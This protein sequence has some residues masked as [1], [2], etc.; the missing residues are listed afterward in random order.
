MRKGRN[1][2]W[3]ISAVLMLCLILLPGTE[4]ICSAGG[5]GAEDRG[6][7]LLQYF[8]RELAPEKI[9]MILAD[10][11]DGEGHVR[12]IYLDLKGCVIGGVRID[13]LRMDAVGVR[14]N[15]PGEWR[16]KGIEPLE[17]LN[18]HAVARLTEY[19]LN[20]NLLQKQFGDDDS[21]RNLQVDIHPGGI[22]A[23][24]NY[25]AQFIF[26]LDI[27]IE[28]FSKFKIVD[29]QQVWLDDYS[30]RVNRMDIP[31]F[32]T[33][34]A[35]A[36]IQPLL[37]LGKFVFPLKLHS[38]EYDEEAITI[39]S[40]VIPEPFPGVVYSWGVPGDQAKK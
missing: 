40:R 1:N 34:K 33:D 2:L 29:M 12:E 32:I 28:I 19:D 13:T 20:E 35:V 22:Y 24:G 9:T 30:V 14:F 21:W 8:L 17:V 11:P 6:A 38:I 15:P 23:R 16:E 26:R 39:S 31:K 10:Q 25:I 5:K 3:G 37:D 18:A 36:E 4:G 7:E 27:L